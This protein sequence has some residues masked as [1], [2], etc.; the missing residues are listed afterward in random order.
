MEL[1][2]VT[3]LLASIALRWVPKP[4]SVMVAS[5]KQR[6]PVSACFCQLL[7]PLIELIRHYVCNWC[8]GRT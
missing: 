7:P 3:D 5:D 2:I 6:S 8:I 1:A 4:Q